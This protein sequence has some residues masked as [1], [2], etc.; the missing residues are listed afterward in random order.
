MLCLPLMFRSIENR[1]Y[2]LY[3][4]GQL[5]SALRSWLPS[6]AQ[7]WLVHRLTGFLVPVGACSFYWASAAA[8]PL[9]YRWPT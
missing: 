7:A 8:V 3:F 6:V 1:Y 4:F 9:F 5:V 2:R